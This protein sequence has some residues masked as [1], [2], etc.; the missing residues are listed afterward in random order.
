MRLIL[1]PACALLLAA[2]QA[3]RPT[4][5]IEPRAQALVADLPPPPM[6]PSPEGPPLSLAE[7]LARARAAS[8]DLAILRERVVQASLDVGRAWAQVKPILN[9]TASY[10]RNQ[11]APIR[12]VE[13]PNGANP[14]V[15]LEEG[16]RNS[17]QGALA[18]QVP[19]FNGRAFPAIATANQLVDV[20][21]LTE[22]EQRIELLLQVAATYYSGV[23]LRELFRV[24][25][26]QAR[27]RWVRRTCWDCSL[28]CSRARRSSASAT[29]R[30]LSRRRPAAGATRTAA[31]C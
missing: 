8:P 31:A 15:L 5:V 18:L 28:D 4:T 19:L 22:A 27:T 23:Q 14:P 3:Q 30:C 1:F 2:P 12:F 16:S 13:N 9:L 24:A 7:A 6:P 21:R 10:T 11:D 26:R 17:V 29:R 20:A 25:F